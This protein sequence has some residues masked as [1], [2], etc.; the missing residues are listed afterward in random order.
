M[1]KEGWISL[2]NDETDEKIE[3]EYL[4]SLAYEG[5]E[6]VLFRDTNGVAVIFDY[7]AEFEIFSGVDDVEL[8]ET[9][10]TLF[11]ERTLESMDFL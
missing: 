4:D 2:Y 10:L 1:K 7:D 8:A 5:R 3:A 9:L 11:K 6:Y